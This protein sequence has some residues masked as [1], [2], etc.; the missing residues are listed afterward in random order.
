MLKNIFIIGAIMLMTLSSQT[1]LKKGLGQIGALNEISGQKLVLF[2]WQLLQNK[3]IILGVVI[4]AVA[5]FCWLVVISRLELTR[6]F[7]IGGGIFYILLFLSAW[8]WLGEAVTL[9]KIFGVA[10][11]LAG[12]YL[13]A[14][15]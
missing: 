3:F 4:A 14:F 7:P 5:A 1:F 9:A 6:A 15:F 2:A 10:V 12:I 11:I 8:L 13:I